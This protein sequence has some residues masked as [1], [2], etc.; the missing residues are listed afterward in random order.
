VSSERARR[1]RR[2]SPSGRRPGGRTRDVGLDVEHGRRVEEIDPGDPY[3]SPL[4]GEQS[5]DREPDRVRALRRPSREHPAG[6]VVEQGHLLERAVPWGAVQPGEDVDVREAGEIAQPRR[7][8]GA[9][10]DDPLPIGL[11]DRLE[12]HPRELGER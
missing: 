5:D 8:L 3:P 7:E 11:R 9:D 1:A 6:L 10:R 4:D 12:Q 2:A